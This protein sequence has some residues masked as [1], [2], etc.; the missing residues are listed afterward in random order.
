MPRD[1]YIFFSFTFNADRWQA[2]VKAVT[3]LQKQTTKC[4]EFL[5]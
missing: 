5:D 4:G 3:N 1:K 2:L